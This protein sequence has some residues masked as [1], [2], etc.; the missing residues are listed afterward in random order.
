MDKFSA[1]DMYR[2]Y[3]R[4]NPDSDVTYTLYKHILSE[5]LKKAADK[6]LDG[7][8]LYLGHK[9]GAIRIKKV[10]R[11]FDK[12]TINWCET[13]KLKAEG[14]NQHVYYTDPYWY[15]WCWDKST[16]ALKNKSVYKFSPTEGANGQKKALVRRLNEDEF[17]YLNYKE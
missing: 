7:E 6:I 12:P 4:S 1:E 17:A 10:E 9:L 14:I 11:N 2:F 16:V 8:V 5:F 13:N 15:R 3:K